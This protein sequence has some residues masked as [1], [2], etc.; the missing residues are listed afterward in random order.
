M[1]KEDLTIGLNINGDYDFPATLCSNYEYGKF[2]MT[3]LKTRRNRA[4][5]IGESPTGTN[6][7]SSPPNIEGA[8]DFVS[9]NGHY[10]RYTTVHFMKTPK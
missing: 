9:C 6:E 10:S 7:V 3:P 5:R 1:V 4:T 8:R 2:S